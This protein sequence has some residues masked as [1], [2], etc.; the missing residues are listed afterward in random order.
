MR[1]RQLLFFT[2]LI[3]GFFTKTYTQTCFNDLELDLPESAIEIGTVTK[4]DE[5]DGNSMAGRTRR[6]LIMERDKNGDIEDDMICGF[7]SPYENICESLVEESLQTLYATDSTGCTSLDR[8]YLDIIQT[9]FEFEHQPA[10][11]TITL[12]N[13]SD[14]INWDI[15]GNMQQLFGAGYAMHKEYFPKDLQ[16][17]V[18]IV[19][20]T[21]TAE[22][23]TF[24][25]L[26]NDRVIIPE[27]NYKVTLKM[28]QVDGK[29]QSSKRVVTPISNS[30]VNFY[31]RYDTV[32]F[33]LGDSVLLNDTYVHESGDYFYALQSTAG[34]DS[35]HVR[36]HTLV[37]PGNGL[38]GTLDNA[39]YTHSIVTDSEGNVFQYGSFYNRED[40]DPTDDFNYVSDEGNFTGIF[41]LTKI[42]HEGDFLWT[43]KITSSGN[44]TPS[45]MVINDED[46]ILLYGKF[47]DSLKYSNENGTISYLVANTENG[48]NRNDAFVAKLNN[49]GDL[50]WIQQI[51]GS[52]NINTNSITYDNNGENFYIT[53]YTSYYSSLYTLFPDTNT[54]RETSSIYSDGF[55]MKLDQNGNEIWTTIFDG[56]RSAYPT[57]IAVNPINGNISFVGYGEQGVKFYSQSNDGIISA[58]DISYINFL[59]TYS[60]NGDYI[61]HFI[62]GRESRNLLTQLAFNHQGEL[63]I[64]SAVNGDFSINLA[65]V[66]SHTSSTDKNDAFLLKLTSNG[67][68]DWINWLE[69]DGPVNT[70]ELEVD[71]EDNLYLTGTYNGETD[72]DWG[73]GTAISTYNAG[74]YNFSGFV[75]KTTAD[76]SYIS[77][78]FSQ[79][80]FETNDSRFDNIALG[81]NDRIWLGGH[82]TLI[83]SGYRN[84]ILMYINQCQPVA[85]EESEIACDQF[86]FQNQNY[87]ES[88]EYIFEGSTDMGCDSTFTLKL[89]I[90]P[91]YSFQIVDSACSYD[92]YP[93]GDEEL[94][95]PG[96]YIFRE[97]SIIG[98]DSIYRLDL[99][100]K[101]T[102]CLITSQENEEIE[103]V[104]FYPNPTND[105]V[106]ISGLKEEEELTF[107]TI[108]GDELDLST[109]HKTS[110]ELSL[111]DLPVG[112]YFIKVG[113]RSYQIVKQ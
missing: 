92:T 98:C 61:S 77:S 18:Y 110:S 66:E 19:E 88:G 52:R 90:Y 53:G 72:F 14:P 76:G 39:I 56:G 82:Y 99:R 1:T 60:P 59:A 9:D 58:P 69:S 107:Y 27:G 6:V 5:I 62:F 36:T 43:K 24:I 31:V 112:M 12:I 28:K 86:S 75:L 87:T 48:S 101:Q 3:V 44:T 89:T 108:L 67:E 64:T 102:E 79:K 4:S 84:K 21:E 20:N 113:E 109:L 105:I 42:S 23:D 33:S 80:H 55:L 15:L 35:L 45:G 93:F 68:F 11:G 47:S 2:F 40:T 29:F 78:Y 70:S 85:I 34:C 81:L 49:E 46:E 22:I 57:S 10:C 41:F 73:D 30:N 51:G 100:A 94:A 32:E 71:K 95:V 103:T 65:G 91:S 74:S 106:Y 104:S 54:I 13:T 16:D 8:Y 63:F 111:K 37:K 7:N 50:L 83:T 96:Q 26:I 25:T 38:I 17:Y 97:T